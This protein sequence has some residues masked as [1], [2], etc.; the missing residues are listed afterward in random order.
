MPL[1]DW[2]RVD[3]GTFHDFHSSWITHLKEAL[4]AGGLPQGYYAMSEQHISRFV[5]D[6][7][8]LQASPASR[9]PLPRPAAGGLALADAPPQ[10]ERKLTVSAAARSRRRTLA[11]RHVTGHR[12]VALLEIVSPANKDRQQHVDDFVAKVTAALDRGIHVTVADLFAPS[13]RDPTGMNGAIWQALDDSGE[14]F[15]L[16]SPT[17]LTL[18]AY[19]ADN[20]VDI[21][22]RYPAI[23]QPLPNMPLFLT[24]DYY[25]QLPLETTYQAA[26]AGMPEVWRSVLEAP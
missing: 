24:P 20:P 3:A 2:S 12:I 17:A 10:V 13:E 25:V 21:Y 6:I 15:E 4:N 14:P 26:F 9:E 22:L 16:P 18:A 8:T 7:L 23:G 5:A 19:D 11:I 1:H